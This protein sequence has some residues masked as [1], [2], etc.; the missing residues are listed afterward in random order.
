[1][2]DKT[3]QFLSGKTVI[4]V[5]VIV[6]ALAAIF[7]A[8]PF[9]TTGSTHQT[10]PTVSAT[11]APTEGQVTLPAPDHTTGGTLDYALE[12]RRSSRAYL[13]ESI[14]IGNLS[15]ILWSAQGITDTASGKRTAPSAM[16]TYP[17]TL[18]VAVSNVTGVSPGVYTYVPETN[19]LSR[20]LDAAGKD[21][22]LSAIGQQQ[23]RSA[24]VT[25]IVSGNT[26]VFKERMSSSDDVLRNLCLEAGHVVQNILLMETSRGMAGVPFTGFNATAVDGHLGLSGNNHVVYAV[27]AAYPADQ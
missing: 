10:L 15:L 4:A 11:L 21:R 24:P 22:V 2:T 16:H 27:T 3:Q 17:L 26:T 14:S 9:F 25:I 13:N 5:I 8:A 7:I 19:S 23:V 1:M 20:H 12:H 6:V 18:Y